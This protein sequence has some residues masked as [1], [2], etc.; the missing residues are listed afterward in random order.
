MNTTV[1]AGIITGIVT[2]IIVRR[3]DAPET[4]EASSSERFMFRNAGVSSITALDMVLPIRWT[5]M[6]PGTL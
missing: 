3:F 5:Q 2:R 6:I 4:R 1:M